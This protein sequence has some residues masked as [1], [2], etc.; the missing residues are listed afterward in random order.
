[1][2]GFKTKK[3]NDKERMIREELMGARQAGGGGS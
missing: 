3:F 2:N 1:M